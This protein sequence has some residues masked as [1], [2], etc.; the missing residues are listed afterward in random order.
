MLQ[1]SGS[2]D[3]IDIREAIDACVRRY[4]NTPPPEGVF[5]MSEAERQ[6]LFR[7]AHAPDLQNEVSVQCLCSVLLSSIKEAARGSKYI[8]PV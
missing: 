7:G 1:D 6:R 3:L 4:L 8:M 5:G 2:P